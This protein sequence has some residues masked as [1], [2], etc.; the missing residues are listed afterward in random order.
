M[1]AYCFIKGKKRGKLY[2]INRWELSK[3]AGNKG[4]CPFT[5]KGQRIRETLIFCFGR[6][7][8]KYYVCFCFCFF[9]FF[10]RPLLGNTFT[11]SPISH[12]V[13]C[14]VVTWLLRDWGL[15]WANFAL[16]KLAEQLFVTWQNLRKKVKGKCTMREKKSNSLEHQILKNQKD[17]SDGLD[18]LHRLKAAWYKIVLQLAQ[19]GMWHSFCKVQ[20]RWL[21]VLFITKFRTYL[22][23]GLLPLL[24][25]SN[26]LA[27]SWFSSHFRGSDCE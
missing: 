25:L 16:H 5:F 22:F 8:D 17:N 15:F 10:M 26:F 3:N 24:D 11:T 14:N 9:V 21:L 2:G 23:L 19:A 27:S 13:S 1:K 4:T 7:F 20:T 18:D 12:A 6:I